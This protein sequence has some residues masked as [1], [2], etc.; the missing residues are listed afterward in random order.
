MFIFAAAVKRYVVAIV[1]F[2][3]CKYLRLNDKQK[4]ENI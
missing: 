1:I 3:K 4:E 2:Y